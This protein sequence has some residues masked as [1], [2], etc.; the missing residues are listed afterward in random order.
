[1]RDERERRDGRDGREHRVRH[2]PKFGVRSSGNLELRTSNPRP[3]RVAASF[4]RSLLVRPDAE[5]ITT[6]K[7]DT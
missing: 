6:R 7:E 4:F 3:S 1:M 2:E 5:R